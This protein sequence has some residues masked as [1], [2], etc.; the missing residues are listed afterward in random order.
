MLQAHRHLLGFSYL[1]RDHVSLQSVSGLY[2]ILSGRI[3]WQEEKPDPAAIRTNAVVTPLAIPVAVDGCGTSLL[4]CGSQGEP[5]VGLYIVLGHAYAVGVRLS[6]FQLCF[7]ISLLRGL[8]VPL[9][10]AAG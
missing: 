3:L 2:R 6:E 10:S 4:V 5:S 8:A 9:C 1:R 7:R